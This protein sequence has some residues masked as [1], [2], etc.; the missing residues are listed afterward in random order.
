MIRKLLC[1]GFSLAISMT[2]LAARADWYQASS[3]HF[4]VYSDDDPGRI[5][6]Y[7]E[8]LE[9]FDK[10]IGAWHVTPERDRGPAS[11]VTIFVVDDVAEV[12]R[13]YGRSGPA[14]YYISRSAG[15]IAIMPRKDTGELSS[16]AI[17]F[18]EYTH[19]WM[20]SNWSDAAFPYWFTEGFAELHATAIVKSD[21]SVTFGAP[22]TYRRWTV[23]ESNLM[24]TSDLLRVTPATNLNGASRDAVYS[25]GWLLL[26]FLTF[27]PE[28]RKQLGNYILA[29]NS[30]K[31]AADAAR[32]FGNIDTLQLK[33]DAWA[34][35][36]Q[37]PT[38]RLTAD[39]LPIGEVTM[40]KLGAGEAAIM[41]ALIRS[42]S[43]VD[44]KRAPIVLALAQR[45]AQPYPD[46]PA[47]QNELAEAEYDAASM[48]SDDAAAIAGFTRAEAAA[49][50]ALAADPKS[51]HALLYKGMAQ[52]QIAI[53]GKV[54]DPARW[55]AIRR[56]FLVAN[57]IDTEDPEPLVQFYDSFGLA[58]EPP[59][60]NAQR[61]LIYAYLLAPYDAGLRARAAR[62]YLAQGEVAEAR[63][64]L[65]P[66]A[67]SAEAPGV[68]ERGQKVLAAIDA[69][70]I[71]GA[72]ALLD[73]KPDE[74][75]KDDG[76]KNGGGS[77]S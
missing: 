34:R 29:I 27:D 18:H 69:K 72:I 12:Q 43:G 24:P 57:K 11:R 70:D 74:D 30:G 31:S 36:S 20:F 56:S 66:L 50:R 23:T 54:T 63:V 47:A 16:Q 13:I 46:D 61:G 49:D 28:R 35:R 55:Q 53:H 9:R 26:D 39:E 60:A 58:K 48:L 52:E 15:P 42:R 4:V 73:A 14:G 76:K 71:K 59:T 21:G 67:F 41:P 2:P 19:H 44:P 77:G 68:A 62:V 45:L 3:K 32:V 65:A 8:R 51:I 33:M 40:R 22:P 5:K 10:A 75:K 37:I 38:T 64:A 7:T 25:R 6:A 1:A 17:L